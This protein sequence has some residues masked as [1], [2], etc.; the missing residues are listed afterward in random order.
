MNIQEV[1][2]NEFKE[3]GRKKE[4]ANAEERQHRSDRAQEIRP[5]LIASG[6]MPGSIE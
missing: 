3:I 4:R 2:D 1:R 5:R 6:S